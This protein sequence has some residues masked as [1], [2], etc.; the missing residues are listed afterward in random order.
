MWIEST[1]LL[2]SIEAKVRRNVCGLQGR[3][4]LRNNLRNIELIPWWLISHN[5]PSALYWL[6]HS[7]S[8]PS[9]LLPNGARPSLL[10]LHF[11]LIIHC[12]QSIL[13]SSIFASSV[14]LRPLSAKRDIIALSRTHLAWSITYSSC[15]SVRLGSIFLSTFGGSTIQIGLLCWLRLRLDLGEYNQL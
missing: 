8:K 7:L 12:S 9:V 3:L 4:V 5:R 15:S 13:Q 2:A 1:P 14:S 6:S 10:P 11:T